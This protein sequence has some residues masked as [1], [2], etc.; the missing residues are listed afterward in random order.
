MDNKRSMKIFL[1]LS[2]IYASC[3]SLQAQTSVP[4]FEKGERVVFVGNSITHAGH[5][6]SFIWLY[7]MTRF[8]DKP[9]TIMNAG[10]GGE[11]AWDIKDRLDYDVFNKKPTY[12]AL[13]FGMNDTGYDIYMKDNARE[14][15][16]RQVARSLENYQGIEQRLLAKNKVTKVLIGGSPYD[17]TSGFNNFILHGK[18]NAILKIIDAQRASA[19]KNGWGFVDFNL[20]MRKISEREQERDSAFTFCRIDRIHPDNDGQMVM[21]Y[22]FLKA[23]GLT[24]NEVSSVSIDARNSAVVASKN[25]KISKLKKNGADLTFD[26]LANALPYPLDSIPR[27]GWGN[28]R[29]Q[30]DAMQL[31]PFME[32]FNQE[33]LQVIDLEEGLYR[34]TIGDQFIDNLSS[35]ELASGVNLAN[36]PNTPQY[37]QAAKIMYLNEE[38]FEIEKR[39]REYLWT[40]CSFLKKEGLLFADN[41]QAID[42]LKEYLPKD[43]FLRASY[44][45][46]IK[47]MHPEIRKVWDD[48]M[49]NIVET[50]YKINKPVTQKVRLTRIE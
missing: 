3:S 6:H 10:I 44:D 27:H 15:S 41:Q 43:M 20:P 4:R 1:L 29:S 31:V 39:F 22:L 28:K 7:Y 21:A 23:Q 34:L 47:A 37:Q 40:E 14:L 33:R 8:P 17:E 32:E 45:W 11:S 9:V 12:V 5:Y 30:R 35:K 48:Y 19:R 24:G 36:Y 26:Y 38:R 42:K 16:E 49:K 46:Y 2:L 13:T 50:I 18:N 25:C